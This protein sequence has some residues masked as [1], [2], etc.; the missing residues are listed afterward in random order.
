[1]KTLFFLIALLLSNTAFAENPDDVPA[2]GST[3]ASI[4]YLDQEASSALPTNVLIEPG[5]IAGFRIAGTSTVIRVEATGEERYAIHLDTPGIEQ[6]FRADY[7]SFAVFTIDV[8]ADGQD[9]I[10]IESGAG[11]GTSVYQRNLTVFRI[12]GDHFISIIDSNLNDYFIPA[13]ESWPTGWMRRYRLLREGESGHVDIM[14][15]LE[16]PENPVATPDAN[17]QI[18]MYNKQLRFRLDEN[19]VFMLV[20]EH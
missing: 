20:G 15:V 18:A 2:F 11:K 13:G 10:F 4:C 8:D 5:T 1:M 6:G 9:E 14:L 19:G 12:T 17:A 16:T 3:L 7:D